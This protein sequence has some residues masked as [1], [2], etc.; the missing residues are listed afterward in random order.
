MCTVIKAEMAKNLYVP[1]YKGLKI[2]AILEK[3]K[4]DNTVCQHLPDERDLSRLPRQWIVNVVYSI[5]GD[6]FRIWV[7]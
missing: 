1:H 3:G 5:I 4:L 6:P 2:E 7:S